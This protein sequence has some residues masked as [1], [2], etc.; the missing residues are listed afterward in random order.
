MSNSWDSGNHSLWSRY[1]HTEQGIRNQE[2]AG[3]RFFMPCCD[4]HTDLSELRSQIT[5][6]SDPHT[7]LSGKR[8]S[9]SACH[10]VT[11]D[12]TSLVSNLM[13][14]VYELSPPVCH[15]VQPIVGI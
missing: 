15:L 11:S 3:V 6:G 4:L 8:S 14:P 1:L 2:S 12:G 9:D 13:V 5:C 7:D 10:A